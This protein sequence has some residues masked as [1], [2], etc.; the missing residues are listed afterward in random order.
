MLRAL[1]TAARRVV[2]AAASLYALA[3]L[4]Y[5]AL[6]WLFGDGFWWLSLLNT[7][8]H[9]LFLPLALLLPSVALLRARAAALRLLPFAALGG[10][11]FLPYWLP[12]P[13]AAAS[14][15]TL[16]V[17][18]LNIWGYATDHTWVEPWA[19]QAGADVI[20]LQEVSPEFARETLPRLRDLYP[21][22]F[23]QQDDPRAGGSATLSRYPIASADFTD[24]QTP[25]TL[26]PLRA[27]LDVNGQ[28]VAVYNVH[29]AWP[30]SQPRL[31]PPFENFFARVALG[32]DDRA[33]NNQI[34]HLVEHLE[35]EPYPFIVGGDFNTSASSVTYQRLAAVMRDSFREAGRGLGASWPVSGRRGLPAFLPPLIRIDYIWH[36]PRF[37]A[38]D[39]RKGPALGSDHLPVIATLELLP[40]G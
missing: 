20:L 30:V 37:H 2:T 13:Q 11:W 17:A 40:E 12:K 36:S 23:S 38:L 39:A 3:M 21:Y 8:A 14:G 1:H 33:R 22:Q 16:R 9:V 34:A 19:R 27:V 5:L 28:P 26:Y 32:F 15:L 31:K 10:V 35:N 18:T 29:L 6:R 4:F 24:V 7:F 25:D